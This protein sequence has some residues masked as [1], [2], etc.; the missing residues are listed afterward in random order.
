M[1]TDHACTFDH[2]AA[3]KE[4]LAIKNQKVVVSKLEPI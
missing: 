2:V 3:Y 1:P 4:L